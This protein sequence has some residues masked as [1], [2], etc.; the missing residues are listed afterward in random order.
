MQLEGSKELSDLTPLS[1]LLW[2]FSA[3]Q[4]QI[5]H[6]AGI[7][8]S[9]AVLEVR[10]TQLLHRATSASCLWTTHHFQATAK[11][12]NG[13]RH[14]DSQNICSRFSSTYTCPFR[15]HLLSTQLGGGSSSNM[16]QILTMRG[17][18]LLRPPS[19]S[20]P[21][22]QQLPGPLLRHFTP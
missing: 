15:W 12:F 6:F 16:T 10:N 9:L 18:E 13:E 11:P 8:G 17:H 7:K 1:I 3:K 19:A 2:K 21:A 14:C 4:Y 22:Q 20:P 5:N